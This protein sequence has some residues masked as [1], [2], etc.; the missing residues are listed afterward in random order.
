MKSLAEI[1]S[2]A[3]RFFVS[4]ENNPDFRLLLLRLSKNGM[5]VGGIMGVIAPIAYIVANVA[6]D[7][8]ALAWSYTLPYPES[9]VLW[10]KLV[11]IAIS[12]IAIVLS[13]S[14]TGLGLNRLIFAVMV[15]ICGFVILFDDV[16][17]QD[18]NF[19]SGYLTILL[20][21]AATCIPY[22]PWQV[23]AICI[24]MNLLVY[25]GLLYLPALAGV[26]ELSI[27]SAQVIYLSI[28]TVILVGLSTLLYHS[29]YAQYVLRRTADGLIDST[30]YQENEQKQR[31]ELDQARDLI[32]KEVFTNN[33]QW[34]SDIT[35]PSTE[36]LFLE[37][38]K[39]AIEQHIGD[40]N[41]GVEWLAHDVALSP[42]QLQRRLRASIGLSAGGLIRVMRLQ[43]AAQ[44]LEQRAG[45]V[46][47]ITY[48]VGFQ[49]PMYFSKIFRQMF[50]TSP[51]EYAKAKKKT[52]LSA[53][54]D[55]E[56]P[57]QNI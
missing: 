46:S 55:L 16:L 2:I 23:L 44:L 21:L 9:M 1:S 57:D 20:L 33:H 39:K 32:K 10:D 31:Q 8:R 43:R 40:S 36:Q 34:V 26:P 19:S 18:I 11:I 37:K 50:D 30:F 49:D 5:L 13:R 7:R 4:H 6:F 17:N 38:V 52:G 45:N 25:P 24:L 29:R 22:K 3:G 54:T 41:F 56:H 42:R 12:A 47:E 48:K 27:V 53:L 28:I 51:S 14:K 35:V 15:F